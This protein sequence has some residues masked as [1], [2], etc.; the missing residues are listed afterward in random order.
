MALKPPETFSANSPG[1]YGDITDTACLNHWGDTA[2]E[3]AS[4]M[5]GQPVT[6]TLDPQ[7]GERGSFGR[8]LAYVEFA[9]ED[10]NAALVELGF[11]R[12]YT[13]DTASRELDYLQLESAARSQRKGLWG[14]VRARLAAPLPTT[15]QAT[16]PSCDP[17][18]PTV[19]IPPRPPDVDCDEIP[20]RNFT[21]LPPDP[22]RFDGDKD[23]VGCEA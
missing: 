14:S 9:G 3:F 19:C 23:G 13:E 1:E 4:I 18:Y 7:A 6:L 21:V 11:A 12:V 17:S 15:P 16:P 20:H 10:I 5:R 22:H 2:T 8:L